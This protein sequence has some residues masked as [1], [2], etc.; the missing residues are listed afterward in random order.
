MKPATLNFPEPIVQGTTLNAFSIAF[1][2]TSSGTPSPLEIASA[3]AYIATS[4]G[5][6][7]HSWTPTVSN[8]TVYCVAVPAAT[9]LDWVVGSNIFYMSLVL[10]SGPTIPAVEG[11]LIV[12]KKP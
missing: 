4:R 2:D 10:T 5:V 1:A 6:V 3:E 12:L 11:K 8:G 7:V 9:T